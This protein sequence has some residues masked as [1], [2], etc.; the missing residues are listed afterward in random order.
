M[1][2][3]SHSRVAGLG[4]CASPLALLFPTPRYPTVT[5]WAARTYAGWGRTWRSELDCHGS[6]TPTYAKECHEPEERA[7]GG[8]PAVHDTPV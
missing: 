3:S 2:L 4:S 6:N 1:V 5:S 7:V 8:H